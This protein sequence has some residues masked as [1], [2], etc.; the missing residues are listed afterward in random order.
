MKITY[1][2]YEKYLAD[3]AKAKSIEVSELKNKLRSCGAPGTS[4]TTAVVKNQAV[5]RLTD[6]K[7]YTGSHKIRADTPT[8]GKVSPSPRK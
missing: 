5:D 2:D 3:L 7:K 8:K 1:Q 6:T 4:G